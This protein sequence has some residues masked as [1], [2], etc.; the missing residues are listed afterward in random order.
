MYLLDQSDWIKKNKVFNLMWGSNEMPITFEVCVKE[1][2]MIYLDDF[3]NKY[4]EQKKK[5]EEKLKSTSL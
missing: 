3:F 5:E 2:F 4:F 1:K